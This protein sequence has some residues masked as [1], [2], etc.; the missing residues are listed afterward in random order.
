MMT[1]DT[2]KLPSRFWAKVNKDGPHGI[3]SQ[4][5]VNLGPCWLWVAGL[6][7]GYGQFCVSVRRRSAKAHVLAYRELVGPIA[8]DSDLDHLC[9]VRR[10]VRPSHLE[11]VTR[12]VNCRRGDSGKHRLAEAAKITHCPSGHPYDVENTRVV[13]R[14]G[15]SSYRACR[16]CGAARCKSRRAKMA[17]VIGHHHC[18]P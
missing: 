5:G 15:R 1:D 2:T 8:P 4:T 9:R 7:R 18:A 17:R 3:H 11:P 13:R 14:P 6:T 12:S 16:I 10:C